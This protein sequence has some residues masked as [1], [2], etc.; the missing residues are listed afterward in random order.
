MANPQA[1]LDAARAHADA[2]RHAQAEALVRRAL[3]SDP[4]H[5]D[6]N[7]A[8]ALVLLHAAKAEQALFFAE[9]AAKASPTAGPLSTLGVALAQ[10]RRPVEA[11][12]AFGRALAH[13][14][15]HIPSV[16]GL[17]NAQRTAHR[18][19]D[20]V[21][22]C[23]GAL[24]L[25]PRD[26]ALVATASAALVDAGRVGEAVAIIEEA[27]GEHPDSP[28]LAQAMLFAINYI[29]LDPRRIF[30]EHVA[31]GR[32]LRRQAGPAARLRAMDG[33]KRLRIGLVSPDFRAHS[34]AY[35]IE[36]VL[37]H[38]DRGRFEVV[39]FNNSPRAD[40]VTAR[41]R[42]H[43]A[44]WHEVAAMTDEGIAALARSRGIDVLVDLSG[45]TLGHRMGVFALRGA[46]VQATFI[47]Y[48]NTTGLDTMD[49]RLVDS[50]TD[51][52]GGEGGEAL[53]VERL[54]RMEGCFLCYRP[55]R[56]A[57]EPSAR[58]PGSPLTLGSFNVL[59]KLSPAAVDLWCGCL[60]RL[61]AARLLLKCNQLA[62]ER[63]RERCRGW[64]GS[65]G[66]DPARIELLPPTPKL[67]EHLALYSRLDVALDT[68]PYTGTT[69][70]C[71]ALWMGVPVVTM[72][73]RMH[74]SRVGSSLLRAAGL[75]GLVATTPAEFVER[76]VGLCED[77]TRGGTPRGLDLRRKLA[78][79]ALTRGEPYTR[80]VEAALREVWRKACA[81]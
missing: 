46:P 24:A 9:R 37:E 28:L 54:W 77:G 41:L 12:E 58:A 39:C 18:Y 52:P 71:E 7:H 22:A 50:I 74:V 16:L 31:Y 21:E 35:F 65:R 70:T 68:Y 4:R 14:P 6:L 72:E 38:H 62:D 40:A 33:E 23:T 20:A 3:Q 10:C 2:G 49:V 36:P 29:D 44:G 11:I 30:E 42:S 48:P 63:V 13:T 69:T 47:G 45:H 57:P 61:P 53:A 32:A 79:S 80:R 27:R 1:I 19:E 75:D 76:V 51:P 60:A 78:A 59:P 56:D 67:A 8:A 55:P 34:V 15:G 25:H 66:I 73:G 17:A 81:G 43:A 5:P 26:P 64:F